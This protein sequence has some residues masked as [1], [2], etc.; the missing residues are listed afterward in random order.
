MAHGQHMQGTG[1]AMAKPGRC[2]A[3]PKSMHSMCAHATLAPMPHSGR[4]M[5]DK[6]RA[7]SHARV[8]LRRAG[9]GC[10]CTAVHATLEGSGGLEAAMCGNANADVPGWIIEGESGGGAGSL[11][12]EVGAGLDH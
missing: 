4:K 11:R 2:Q 1:S 12:V 7:N 10:V 3:A 5:Q 6:N 9:L 8:R